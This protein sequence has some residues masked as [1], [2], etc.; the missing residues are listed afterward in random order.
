[1]KGSR[2]KVTDLQSMENGILVLNCRV[3]GKLLLVS[4]F[5][6]SVCVDSEPQGNQRDS[7]KNCNEIVFSI[8]FFFF[9]LCTLHS[10]QRFDFDSIELN[11]ML[12]NFK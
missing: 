8:Y 3:G 4:F 6:H 2:L 9:F 10:F 11:K 1:M 7:A 5:L 12:S